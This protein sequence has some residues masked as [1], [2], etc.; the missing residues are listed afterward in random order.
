[1][2]AEGESWDSVKLAWD[3]LFCIFYWPFQGD[4]IIV[5]IFVKCSVVF[6]LQMIFSPITIM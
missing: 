1:M 3:P 4:T 2:E 6:H 5:V